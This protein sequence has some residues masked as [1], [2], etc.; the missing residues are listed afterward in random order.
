MITNQTN[1]NKNMSKIQEKITKQKKFEKVR[2][3]ITF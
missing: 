3:L 2:E 1:K